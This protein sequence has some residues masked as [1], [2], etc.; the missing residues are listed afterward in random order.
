M[1]IVKNGQFVYGK[2][3]NKSISDVPRDYIDYLIKENT[4]VNLQLGAELDRR[5]GLVRSTKNVQERQL[6][7]V[8]SAG[9]TGVDQAALR[10]AREL[11]ITTCGHAFE[12]YMTDTGPA[13]WLEEYGLWPEAR[14]GDQYG[15]NVADSDA[16]LIF[17]QLTGGSRLVS[18]MCNYDAK[19]WNHV[20]W[21]NWSSDPWKVAEWIREKN[22]GVLHVAGNREAKNPGIGEA[23]EGFLKECLKVVVDKD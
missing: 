12:R 6:G 11:E 3:K 21:P 17:G 4:N 19:P 9:Q 2:H 1:S 10:A 18:H 8:I 7:M 16:T 20:H 23:V 22:V 5:E 14:Y 13:K 15:L